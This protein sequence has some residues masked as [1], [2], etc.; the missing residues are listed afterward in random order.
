MISDDIFRGHG[1]EVRLKTTS[2]HFLI[3]KETLTRIGT[4]PKDGEKV[5]H[6][7]CHIL[8]KRGRYAIVHWKELH[9]LDGVQTD[10]SRDDLRIRNRAATLL[11][12]WGLATI[13]DPSL[14]EDLCPM[15]ALK[16]L[17]TEEK[18]AGEWR[19]VERYQIG[20]RRDGPRMAA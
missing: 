1:V 6:Q 3:V 19:L 14:C 18:K 16:V 4:A 12:Q 20:R 11:D 5:L 9:E 2:N 8:H 13:V 17:T 15:S 10:L 7:S